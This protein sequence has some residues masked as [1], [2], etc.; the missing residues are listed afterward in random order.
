MK[1]LEIAKYI[2]GK[3]KHTAHYFRYPVFMKFPDM[4]DHAIWLPSAWCWLTLNW[5]KPFKITNLTRIPSS[6]SL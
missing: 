4:G 2:T 3:R 5:P 6:N 1:S